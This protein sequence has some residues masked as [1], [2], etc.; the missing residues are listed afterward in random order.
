MWPAF[1]LAGGYPNEEIDVFEL[2]GER[3]GKIHVDVHCPND[4]DD[5]K[6]WY[7]QKKSWGG[8]IS[9]NEKLTEGFNVIGIEW[10]PTYIKYFLNTQNLEFD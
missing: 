4:C 3:P 10:Q 2:K 7:G 8:W 9:L 5:Y 1:W 6:T